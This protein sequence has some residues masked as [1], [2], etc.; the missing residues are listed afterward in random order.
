METKF[1]GASLESG[2]STAST[3]ADRVAIFFICRSTEPTAAP[4]P[5][6]EVK[7]CQSRHWLISTQAT[8]DKAQGRVVTSSGRGR[9]GNR[10]VTLSRRLVDRPMVD[11]LYLALRAPV[12]TDCSSPSEAATTDKAQ[13][14]LGCVEI[15]QCVGLSHNS[16]HFSATTWPS[17][18]LRNRQPMTLSMN[19]QV[20]ARDESARTRR[21][22]DF[23][24]GGRAASSW[25]AS[26]FIRSR[27]CGWACMAWT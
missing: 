1:Y 11:L 2:C 27:S 5:R 7:N 3:L 19:M 8:T 16:S 20:D 23:H 17:W 25:L 6:G 26:S 22:F 14:V 21:K 4:S 18:L 12:A 15:N 10:P 9:C 13:V 24:T